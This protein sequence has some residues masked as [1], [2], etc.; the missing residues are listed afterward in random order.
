MHNRLKQLRKVLELNQE[1]FAKSLGLGKSSIAMIETGERA[2]L[3]RHIKLICTLWNVNR[4]WLVYGTGQMFNSTNNSSNI[5]NITDQYNLS[6]IE[7]LILRNYLDMEEND[8]KIFVDML[9]KLVQKNEGTTDIEKSVSEI[10]DANKRPTK[11]EIKTLSTDT[12]KNQDIAAD[13]GT[14][15]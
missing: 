1:E 10:E 13:T 5:D 7:S 8:R 11:K 14:K 3:D 15:F 6:G 2:L 12:P 4:D 9:M